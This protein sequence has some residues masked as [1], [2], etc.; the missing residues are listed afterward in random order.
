MMLTDTPSQ[1]ILQHFRD[2]SAFIREAHIQGGSVF[3]HCV[4]GKS[5]SASC[6]IAFLI[7]SVGMA[8]HDALSMLQRARPIVRPN[9]GFLI[10]LTHYEKIARAGQGGHAA[11]GGGGSV[12]IH[13]QPI[14]YGR[15]AA[16]HEQ[17]S[18]P[19]QPIG[20]P[21]HT[22]WGGV[23]RTMRP[24]EFSAP[25]MQQQSQQVAYGNTAYTNAVGLTQYE[26]RLDAHMFESSNRDLYSGGPVCLK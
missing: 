19:S 9:E 6:V 26:N 25:Q 14:A 1:N 2:T 21:A 20:G 5:R 7:D 23:Q 22:Q 16:L 18:L 17:T 4:E 8:L 12:H 15:S 11:Q 3:L 10:Q 13:K 24:N